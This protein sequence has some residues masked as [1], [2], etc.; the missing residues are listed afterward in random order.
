MKH[1]LVVDDSRIIRKV[2]CHILQSLA[3][4]T[5]EAEDGSA[6]L[7]VCRRNMPELVLLDWNMPGASGLEFLRGL[8][9]EERGSEPVVVFCVTEN[10]IAGIN[11]AMTAGAN[12]YVL[13]PFDRELI[14]AK[15]AQVGLI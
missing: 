3:F 11:E 6:A 4:E 10:D 14:E 5:D 13:K 15:L 7:D 1:C 9:R 8:R 12:D 2:A